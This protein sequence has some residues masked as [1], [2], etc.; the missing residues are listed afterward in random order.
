MVV[1]SRFRRAWR[2]LCSTGKRCSSQFDRTLV[3]V[4]AAIFFAVAPV[5]AKPA[6][7]AHQKVDRGLLAALRKGGATQSVILTMKPGCRPDVRK[8]LEQHGDVVKA[9]HPLIEGLSIQLHSEDV[10][11]LEKPLHSEHLLGW[12]CFDERDDQPAV[13]TVVHHEQACRQYAQRHAGT[14]PY[15]DVDHD[16]RRH[17]RRRG[18]YRLG[19]RAERRLHRPHY[20]LLRFHAR[21]HFHG[22]VRRL[23]SRHAH[24]RADRQQRQT[25]ELRVSGRGPRREHGRAKVLDAAG[26]GKTSDVISALEFVIANRDRLN[27]Q[28]INLS[29]GHPIYAP[30]KDDPLVQE[31]EK[32]SAA[33]LIVVT[34]AGNQGERK[35]GA[36]GYTGITSPGNA[37]SA[38]TVGSAMTAN[39]TPRNDDG[40]APYSSRGPSWFDAFAKP[41]VVAPG[42]QLLSD[43]SLTSYLYNKLTSSQKSSGNGQKFLQLSGSS[44]ARRRDERCGGARP[45]AAQSKRPS[46]AEA[47]D[48]K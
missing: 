15:C 42:H 19:H 7:Q 21:R 35:D 14:T 41:D 39:T 20:R 48:G 9:E 13:R 44:M 46:Q 40:V 12:P 17:R 32:A 24:R 43:A 38:I 34:S 28:I 16:D 3:A 31:V 18:H 27:V 45:P 2:D 11:E 22:A 8:A 10:D 29:L 30:A 6:E 25:F 4:T 26:Q 33:G 47:A 23:R 37:P 36:S 1:C 5:Y